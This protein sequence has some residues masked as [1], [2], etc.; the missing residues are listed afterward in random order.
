[1]PVCHCVRVTQHGWL[2]TQAT[3]GGGSC[4]ASTASCQPSLPM[5]ACDLH[6]PDKW[7][8]PTHNTPPCSSL[9]L[10]FVPCCE[11]SRTELT[12]IRQ[13]DACVQVTPTCMCP[14]RTCTVL[15]S[16]CVCLLCP[17]LLPLSF[18]G[19]PQ[20]LTYLQVRWLRMLLLVSFCVVDFCRP[21]FPPPSHP[22]AGASAAHAA[23]HCFLCCYC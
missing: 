13:H 16:G 11:P 3:G 9:L 1:M 21:I 20:P 12:S 2:N 15:L 17:P 6:A 22:P 23:S 19:L 8:V 4:C 18:P 10:V 7:A 5:F 14:C